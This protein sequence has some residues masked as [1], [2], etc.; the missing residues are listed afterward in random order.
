M[1]IECEQLNTIKRESVQIGGPN[2]VTQTHLDC[3]CVVLQNEIP[4][5]FSSPLCKETTLD[6]LIFPFPLWKSRL[7]TLHSIKREE[8][9]FLRDYNWSRLEEFSALPSGPAPKIHWTSPYQ[10]VG[11]YLMLILCMIVIVVITYCSCKLCLCKT[12]NQERCTLKSMGLLSQLPHS[13]KAMEMDELI[14]EGIG[15]TVMILITI[16]GTVTLYK[17]IVKLKKRYECHHYK[18]TDC[19]SINGPHIHV[20]V[21]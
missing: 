17:L 15:L 2:H 3:T 18:V 19:P 1:V 5:D 13:V 21:Y 7:A 16:I 8:N 9:I 4:I 20:A 6:T 12:Q 14:V 10:S 11:W